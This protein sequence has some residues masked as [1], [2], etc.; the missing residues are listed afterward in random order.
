[1]NNLNNHPG[2]KEVHNQLEL[3][4]ENIKCGG[5]A[6][7][8]TQAL[9][10]LKFHQISV[11][12]E[13]QKILVSKPLNEEMLNKA[14]HKLHELGY[15]LVDSEEGLKALALKAKSYISCALGKFK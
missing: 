6:K 12:H 1:M 7:T 15:P 13:T 14:I 5:C 11:D 10:D 3:T 4:V 2:I 8:I 9:E